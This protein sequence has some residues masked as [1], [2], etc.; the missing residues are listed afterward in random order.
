MQV[1]HIFGVC[2][3]VA[4]SRVLVCPHR[5]TCRGRA[6]APCT[7][8]PASAP[9]EPAPGPAPRSQPEGRGSTEACK[10]AIMSYGTDGP[11]V[12]GYLIQTT[13][14]SQTAGVDS[15]YVSQLIHRA[16]EFFRQQVD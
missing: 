16:E 7:R 5:L 15:G 6:A 4:W 9:H 2:C 13:H 1:A 11:S 10:V 14:T 12:K 8:P 3:T